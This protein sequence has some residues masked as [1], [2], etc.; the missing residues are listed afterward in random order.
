MTSTA[1]SAALTVPQQGDP[2]PDL[3]KEALNA[4]S[5]EDRHQFDDSSS[6]QHETLQKVHEATENAKEA[7][8]AKG[9]NV[10]RKK[11]GEKIK[12]RH[13]LEKLSVWVES[14]IKVI[15]L[16]V[17][18]DQSGHAA[19]PW[20]VVKFIVTMGKSKKLYLEGAS[21]AKIGLRESITKFYAA[22]LTYLARA[23]SYF[24]G[25]TL[26][27]IGRGLLEV[28][29]N[30]Y[31]AAKVSE[32][33]VHKWMET[34]DRESDL[35]TAKLVTQNYEVLKTIL[36]D[37]NKPITRMAVQMRD[38]HDNFN[39]EERTKVFHWL[40]KID[41]ERHHDDL[42]KHLLPDTGQ[43]L[44]DSQPFVDWGQSSV[45]SILWLHGIPG[46]GKTRLVSRII[47]VMRNESTPNRSPIAFFYCARST[48]E[49]ER[50]KPVEVLG[51][52]LKQLCSSDPD[53]PIRNSIA[54]EIRKLSV[55]DCT[56]LILELTKDSPAT[57]VVDALDECD[58]ET[59]YELL[60]ALDKIIADSLEVV[61]VVVSSRDVVDIVSVFAPMLVFN[62]PLATCEIWGNTFRINLVG[63]LLIY[64]SQ[65][66]RL[67][68]CNNISISADRNES[69]IA[70]FVSSEVDRLISKK[71]LLDGRIHKKL[72][73][74]IIETLKSGAQGMFRWVAMSLETLQQIKSK[75]EFE[76]RLGRLPSKLSGL[77]D[78]IHSEI[79]R[80][81]YGRVAATKTL[82]WLLCAQRLLTV[83]ELAAAIQLPYDEAMDSSSASD[84]SEKTDD[85]TND[86]AIDSS[87]SSDDSNQKGIET[88]TW[89]EDNIIRLC[90]NL[91]VVDSERKVFRFA[92]QSVREYLLTRKEYTDK[93]QHTLVVERCFEIYEV[94]TSPFLLSQT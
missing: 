58:E 44:F 1:A 7:C 69:D 24:S 77:Y 30:H 12:L 52:I 88:E 80:S 68:H 13:V 91:V 27:Q 16:G 54:T 46:S 33:E 59:R 47:D 49:P 29:R 71:L 19:L 6:S 32:M 55:E 14:A 53:E 78:I 39:R 40:S 56:R 3:W 65:K 26:K 2:K 83:E 51:A 34:V 73:K 93:E 70:R 9:W 81:E 22:I 43:W 38:L 63:E 20:G 37:F 57:I 61:K 10:Y 45:S 5:S 67:K 94:E 23:K 82:K 64:P 85:E 79:I 89:I 41:Y 72:R 11:N 8:V 48:A 86:Q 31:D 74:R 21:E 92:H 62:E 42:S 76:D 15:D 84:D 66:L 35:E 17:S 50:G 4:L 90:R 28:T 36:R 60:E 25:N 18:F 75:Q 87:S